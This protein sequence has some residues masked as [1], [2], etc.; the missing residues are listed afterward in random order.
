MIPSI[1][2]QASNPKK[3]GKRV[4]KGTMIPW[5]NEAALGPERIGSTLAIAVDPNNSSFIY[6]AWGDQV[7][8][9]AIYTIHVKSSKDRGQTWS[10]DLRTIKNAT[11]ISLA[12]SETGIVGFLYQQLVDQ[13][14]HN[15]WITILEQS[16]DGFSSQPQSTILANVSAELEQPNLPYNGDYNCLLA[17]NDRFE[18]VF[19]ANNEPIRSNFPIIPKYQ[20]S[21]DWN[22]GILLDENDRPVSP[23]IDPFFFSAPVLH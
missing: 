3:A 14:N 17:I 8:D 2:R 20:R 12:V 5:R 19:A 18:G 22:R 23:S 21:V 16:K 6:I 4:V 11:S 1:N 10:E 13:N 15:R 7:N 9:G